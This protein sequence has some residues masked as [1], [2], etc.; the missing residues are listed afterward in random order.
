MFDDQ[1]VENTEENFIAL[2]YFSGE[3]TGVEIGRNAVCI[4]IHDN[5]SKFYFL[6]L[7]YTAIIECRRGKIF[8]RCFK[9]VSMACLPLLAHFLSFAVMYTI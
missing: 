7:L 5:D 3:S 1:I 6:V 9:P 2:L 8:V 4:V